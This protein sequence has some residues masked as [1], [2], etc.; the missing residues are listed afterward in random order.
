MTR[1]CRPLGY[2]RRRQ[3]QL[4]WWRRSHRPIS[5]TGG[6]E[7]GFTR[8]TG[9]PV[10]SSKALPR[11]AGNLDD[12]TSRRRALAHRR[13]PANSAAA[14]CG[15]R[16]RRPDTGPHQRPALPTASQ[17]P[18]MPGR[19]DGHPPGVA[20]ITGADNARAT[21]AQERITIV[22]PSAPA[23]N[24]AAQSCRPLICPEMMLWPTVVLPL[25]GPCAGEHPHEAQR[26]QDGGGVRLDRHDVDDGLGSKPGPEVELLSARQLS[27]VFSA[28]FTRAACARIASGQGLR[29]RSGLSRWGSR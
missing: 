28:T 15:R 5:G 19:T 17:E 11:T 9:M 27:E 7:P 6:R 13:V 3:R 14:R 4:A 29:A 25:T 22:L 21:E 24:P 26:S 23:R 2:G 18:A 10:S 8:S 1:R 12:R 16:S 20:V